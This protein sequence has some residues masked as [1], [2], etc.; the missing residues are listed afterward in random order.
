MK[1]YDFTHKTHSLGY[2][3]G[4]WNV[5]I[6]PCFSLC[7][8]SQFASL[9]ATFIASDNVL[10]ASLFK[11]DLYNKHDK[12]KTLELKNKWTVVVCMNNNHA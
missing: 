11:F 9:A 2:F 7:S 8:P 1:I 4:S 10:N 6:S 12:R 5:C 3:L